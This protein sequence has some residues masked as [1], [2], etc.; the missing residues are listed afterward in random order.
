MQ[1]LSGVPE[2]LEGCIGKTSIWC[3]N[4]KRRFLADWISGLIG[5]EK[6]E[7]LFHME[8]ICCRFPGFSILVILFVLCFFTALDFLG[9]NSRGLQY[10]IWRFHLGLKMFFL[11]NGQL[12]ETSYQSQLTSFI[13]GSSTSSSGQTCKNSSQCII[14]RITVTSIF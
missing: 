1:T 10:Y 13:V 5:M 9:Y 7:M 12:A 2:N 3:M 8:A 4:M 14:Y 6:A 11:H